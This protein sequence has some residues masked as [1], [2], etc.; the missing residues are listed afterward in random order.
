[1]RNLSIIIVLILLCTQSLFCGD[2]A[3]FV[4]LGFSEDSKYFMFAQYGIKQS[5]SGSYADLFFIDVPKNSFAPHGEKSVSNNTKT[6]PGT[7]GMGALFNIVEENMALTT[8]YVIDHLRTGRI[9]Y[10]LMDGEKQKESFNFRDFIT[11][12]YYSIGLAQTSSGTDKSVASSF[13]ISFTI[14]KSA[15]VAKTYSAGHPDHKRNGIK[16]YKI[17][18]ILLSPDAHSLIFIIE[19]EEIDSGGSNIRYMVEAI[20]TE[21]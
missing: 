21:N 19:K 13:G 16:S 10:H 3:T 11:G 6:E 1:M 8:R 15:G 9:L 2:V 18:Q 4:N 20:K 5:N 7:F 12:D 14:K 17:R